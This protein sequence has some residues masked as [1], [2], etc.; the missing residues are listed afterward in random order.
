MIRRNNWVVLFFAGVVT[1]IQL[2]NLI[3]GIP[4]ILVATVLGILLCILGPLAYISN[5]PQW[6]EKM[7]SFTKYFNFIIIGVSMFI[8]IAL[9]PHL[10]NIMSLYF[11]VAVM[12]IYQ[13]KII[14]ICTIVITLFTVSYYFFTQGE[15]IFHT[16]DTMDLIYFLLTF[17]MVSATSALHS[18][19]NNKLHKEMVMQKA[20]AIESKEKLQGILNG[21]NRSV[22][23]VKGYQQELNQATDETNLR[24][25]EIVALLDEMLGSFDLQVEN[26]NQVH[27]GMSSTN[28]RVE[29]MT[30]SIADMHKNVESTNVA[31]KQ[32]VQRIDLL[33]SD[34]K[35][36]N[37]DIHHTVHLMKELTE[38]TESIEKISQSIGN[39]S[40]QTNLLAL[41]ASIEAVRAG[42]QGKGF[43]VVAEEVR[44]LAESSKL[45]TESIASLL[46]SI[47]S[48]I[49]QVSETIS[50]S[51]QSIENNTQGMV[52]VK[53]IFSTVNTN[54]KNIT[55][56]TKDLQTFILD[57][58]GLMKEV[59]V[60]VEIN[61][62]STENNKGSLEDSLTLVSNQQHDIQELSDGFSKLE[63]S[64]AHLLVKQ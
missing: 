7:A 16:T 2:L 33:E 62:H 21:V 18:L 11:Y 32:S 8:I 9:D 22:T 5:R 35:S 43:A 56:Q 45:S 6:K 44:K 55:H 17:C 12:G 27:E 30:H 25:T 10:I 53:G 14:N 64:I 50:R 13:D 19:F 39:I 36:F 60:G 63:E 49:N 47:R 31:T 26:S 3:V 15:L 4:F 24:S 46:M 37:G 38:E 57:V 23:T 48:K 61:R 42:E 34:L 29:D 41:N 28:S 58:Q 51:Q 20:E 59:S 40:K 1:A 52:E 54:M